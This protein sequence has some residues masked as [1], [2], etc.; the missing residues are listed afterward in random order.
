[1]YEKNVAVGSA[2]L[3]TI[4]P[5]WHRT[6]DLV[7]LDVSGWDDCVLGQTIGGFA[8]YNEI[9]KNMALAEERGFL[10]RMKGSKWLR[11]IRELCAYKNL[12]SAWRQ[13]I[14]R[15]KRADAV[16]A[17]AIESVRGEGQTV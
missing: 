16:M 5:G 2:W 4:K 1:M 10:I 3:D 9:Y 11:V 13:E 14:L 17:A 8:G 6:I 12:T 15:R 7:R